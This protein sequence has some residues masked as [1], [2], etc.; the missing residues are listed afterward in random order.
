MAVVAV[1]LSAAA[2]V[3]GLTRGGG[4]LSTASTST[5]A[6]PAYTQ[7]EAAAAHQKL[8]DT[9]RLAARS[10]DIDTNTDNRA[11]ADAVSANAAVM[12]QQAV[13]SSPAM[14]PGDR[15]AALALAAAYTKATAMGSALWRDDPVFR[16]EIDDVNAKDAVMKKICSGG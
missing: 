5:S 7:E 8:C 12:L 2:L 16:S 6:P 15:V 10:V 4:G 9:Y 1:L 3:V 14:P 11:L 13:S